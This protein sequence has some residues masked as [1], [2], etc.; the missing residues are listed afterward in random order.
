MVNATGSSNKKRF[1]RTNKKRWL[2]Y[3]LSATF[4]F[5]IILA[6]SIFFGE[7]TIWD[8]QRRFTVVF[9]EYSVSP[10]P[11]SYV[12]V[13]S[14]EPRLN[15][16]IF[17][18]I[19]G[20]VL[21]EAPYGYKTYPASSIF[22]LGELDNKRGGGKLLAKSIEGTLGIFVDGYYIGDGIKKFSPKSSSRALSD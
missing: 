1:R 15:R 20:N 5:L 4:I 12:Y 22:L 3:F 21:L 9:Q 18:P 2:W 17:L 19:P 6:G 13:F 7:K 16:A 14:I 8:G 10:N 11:E